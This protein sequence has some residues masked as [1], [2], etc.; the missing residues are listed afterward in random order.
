MTTPELPARGATPH[1]SAFWHGFADMSRVGRAEFAL[2]RG[3]GCSVWDVDGNE[4]LD[5]TAGL[6][7]ANVGHGRRAIAEAMAEQ[8]TRL[9]AYSSFGDF[10]VDTTM[11]L[12]DEVAALSPIPNSRVFFTS[13]GSDS[14]DTAVKM[15]RR[16]AGLTAAAGARPRTRIAVLTHAY[17]GMHQG[18]TALA[19]IP[20]NRENN[21]GLDPDVVQLAHG[22]L[23][24][25]I[26]QLDAAGDVAAVFAEPV[27]G[28][29]GV[30][31]A[32]EDFLR[33][34]RKA[35]AEREALFVADEVITGFGR[36]GEWFASGLMG[37]EPDLLLCAKGLTS[38]YAPMGAVLASE[39]IW[40]P[41]YAEGAGV[42][43]HG[44]TYGGHAVAAAA[45][46]ANLEIMRAERLPEHVAAHADHL[47][48]A[49]RAATADVP[50]VSDV[51]VAPG[52]LAA[53][54]L[55]EPGRID[56]AIMA[57]RRHGVLTRGLVGGALQISPPL[58]LSAAEIDLLA[59]RLT[60]A[61]QGM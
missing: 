1:T 36:T 31:F 48:S 5:A 16:W 32:G 9:A 55:A 8:A 35:C 51:R 58:T 13:G 27:T 59:S 56:E 2:H 39:R 18:G 61:L 15:V 52:Y 7:F 34:L 41:F 19:G 29:G 38:G 30:H 20:A 25:A 6:W 22:D 46:L 12:A 50:A 4:Y 49:L 37:L 60:P 11:Q 45:G 10:T 53:V 24:Q 33:G 47:H 54:Q 44:Y 28:A 57:V 43:R 14:V 21:P 23:D 3:E 26:A 40:G 42:W 17:H